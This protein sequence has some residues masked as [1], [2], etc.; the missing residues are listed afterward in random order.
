[1]ADYELKQNQSL[2]EDMKT[3]YKDM[4]DGT[5][6]EVVALEDDLTIGVEAI[7][8]KTDAAASSTV[9]ETGTARSGISLWKGIKNIL[10]L[11]STVLGATDGAAIV[12]DSDGTIQR[13]LRGLVKLISGILSVKGTETVI[14]VTLTL[15]NAVQYADGDVL[16][17][18]KEI[19]NWVTANGKAAILHHVWLIDEDAQGGAL[20]LLFFDSAVNVGTI[21]VAYD[22]TDAEMEG[23]LGRIVIA[24]TDYTTWTNNKTAFIKSSDSGFKAGIMQ[25]GAATTSIWIAGISRDTKTYTASGIKLKLGVIERQ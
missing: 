13:Y 9:A 16:F 2:P 3:R 8:A 4:G 21:N 23:L 19:T 18:S 14:D 11:V 6:A 5:H 25:A 17:V 12:T 1:M 10:I 15:D 7:G 20:D 24:G 22:I